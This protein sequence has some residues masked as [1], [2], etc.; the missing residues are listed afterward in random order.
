L[1]SDPPRPSLHRMPDNGLM[2]LALALASAALFVALVGE[3]L[4]R[5]LR[6]ERRAVLSGELWRLLT[7]HLVHLGWAHLALNAAAL[8]LVATLLGRQF[9][10]GQWAALALASSVGVGLGLLLGSPSVAWYVGLSGMS[11]GL[12]AA[13]VVGLGRAHRGAALA[14]L[15]L[16]AG[17]LAWEHVLGAMPG[18]Q[19][20]IGG[21]TV[22][23]AHLYG[24]ISGLLAALLL[25]AWTRPRGQP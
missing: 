13:G 6:Y 22:V 12:V 10:A 18:S 16:L 23:D 5:H 21:A 15:A 8:F 4:A 19:A 25:A 24:A 1:T 7:A 3:P 11:H 17:K 2:R 14:G 20:A 9:R